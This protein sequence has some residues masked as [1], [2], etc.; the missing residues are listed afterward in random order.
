MTLQAYLDSLARRFA[1]GHAREHAYRSD[2]ELLLRALAPGVDITNEPANVTDCGN[3]DFVLMRG[4]IPVGYIEAKDLGKDLAAKHYREQFDR[5]RAALDNLIITDYLWF[6]FYREGQI[7]HEIRIGELRDGRVVALPGEFS[8]FQ[9]LVTDFATYT[10]QT[11]KSPQKLAELMAAKARLLQDILEKAVSSD[12]ETHANT[13][14]KEQFAGFK[15]VL[16]HD[17][18]PREFSDLYAQTLA[19]GLFAARLHDPSLDS[20]SR[21]EAANLI[22]RTNP[23]L[24]WLFQ[25]IAGFDMDE[26][27]RPTT[28]NL[29]DVFRATNVAEL[30]SGYG[31]NTRQEDPVIHF[32]ETFLAA[33]DPAL[34]KSRGVW[35]T[36]EPVVRFIVRAVDDLLK[37]EF[38]LRDG[39]ADT[40]KIK[41]KVATDNFDKRKQDYKQ[42]EREVHKVQILDPATGTGTFLAEVVRHLHRTRFAAMPGAWPQ[43][44]ER[45]LIPR[46]NGFELLMASYA[47]AHLKLDLLLNELAGDSE[48][49]TGSHRL[50]TSSAENERFRIFLT[51]SLEEHHP[52]T[53]T[54]FASRLSQE[55]NEANAVKRDT[56]VMVVLGNPPYSGISSNMG[57]WVT[58]LIEDYK[59]VDGEHFGERKH[60]LQDDYVKFIR[61]GQHLVDKNGE[62]VLAYINNHSFLD[63]PTFR[64]MRWHLLQSFDTIYILDLHG[65]AKKKEVSPDG[66][67]DENVF[68]IQQ[69]VSINIFVKN[70]KKKKGELAKVLHCDL[71]GKREAK[72]QFL[73]ENTLSTVVFKEV[74]IEKPFLFFVPTENEGKAEYE[75]GFQINELFV[76]STVGFVTGRDDINIGFS[77]E[78]VNANIR[79]LIENEE[80]KIRQHFGLKPT[81]AR[82]WTVPTAKK[83]AETNWGKAEA[84]PCSYRPF[85]TRFTFYTGNSRGL[86]ASPQKKVLQHFLKGENVGLVCAKQMKEDPGAF[87]SQ[88]IVAHKLFSAYDINTAFPLYLYPAAESEGLFAQ[89]QRQPNLN[90]SI[91]ARIAEELGLRYEPESSATATATATATANFFTPLDLLDYIY[92]VLHSPA[93]RERYKEFLKID[94][95]RVPYPTDAAEFRRL[96]RLGSE[97]RRYHLLEHPDT[98]KFITTYPATGDNAVAKG[99]PKWVSDSG[100]DRVTGSH[101]VN[102]GKVFINENQYFAGVP[103]SVWNFYIGGYQPAQKWLKDRRERQLGWEDLLHYQRI[104]VALA[105]TERLMGEIDNATKNTV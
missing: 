39:L 63:N 49:V 15:Q 33:Y 62:G 3:P 17:L 87:I 37:T 95:P 67:K 1:S 64:G 57:A 82:D 96:V 104:V 69:G 90:E 97:L 89:A 14:L 65:N 76:Q 66:S 50:T 70:G 80:S 43:Y 20:F 73:W 29:A 68:D 30:L 6:R 32:Y 7:L 79:F 11:I 2:L 16:L 101:P 103:E 4:A 75:K 100:I 8:K 19:Y 24:R 86:Y 41:I 34:R 47:M 38:G 52:D 56:P 46:L 55:A 12:E 53:G 98:D 78:E 26:R 21:Q 83:D 35:Y 31:R 92:A 5:Y 10:G 23:F 51:N 84:V 22:P 60:W 28:D 94:F 25:Q 93:Y 99:C 88:N 71:W 42:A 72:Y 44:V 85:D 18:T 58:G 81:D 77:K 13:A 9:L 91:V 45:D 105:A 48:A 36:P 54:L 61:L 27:L 102:T 40:S 59:Y 74:K